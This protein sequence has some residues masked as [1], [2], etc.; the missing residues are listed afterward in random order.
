MFSASQNSPS[1]VAPS[2][3]Q[4]SVTSPALRLADACRLPRT[5]PPAEYWV[6]VGEE[7]LTM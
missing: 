4:T 2:P 5:P 1:L 7:E 3:E 6:P